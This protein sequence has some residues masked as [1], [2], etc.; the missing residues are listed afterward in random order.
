MLFRSWKNKAQVS[1]QLFS[2]ISGTTSTINP[3]AVLRKFS[4]PN[5]DGLLDTETALPDDPYLI[6]IIS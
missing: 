1:T 5:C 2:E 3:D 6:D 4:C